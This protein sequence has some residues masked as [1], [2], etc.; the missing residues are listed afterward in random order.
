MLALYT[1]LDPELHVVAQGIEG[2]FVERIGPMHKF[3][4]DPSAWEL[5]LGRR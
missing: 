5:A 2:E 1:I 4:T 3:Y